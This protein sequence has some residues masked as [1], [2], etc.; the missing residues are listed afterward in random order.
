MIVLSS[1]IP[2]I[3]DILIKVFQQY[4]PKNS[5]CLAD[6][7]EAQYATTAA[8][9]FPDMEK[10][11]TLP[12]L[13]LIHSVAAGVEHLNLSEIGSDQFV[14]RILDEH[15]Q[16]GMFDYLHWG[17]LYYQRHFDRFMQ[18]QR[19]QAQHQL[20]AGR[21]GEHRA[22][23]AP[24]VDLEEA[25]AQLRQHLAVDAVVDIRANLMAAGHG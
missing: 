5:Y 2:D 12:K 14:C 4:A 16:K 3:Q 21:Q 20:L 9:W 17:V 13:R 1:S 10:L 18:Q 15:H 25:P 8:C 24:T 23:K 7:P 19:Q 22:L 11:R 6:S